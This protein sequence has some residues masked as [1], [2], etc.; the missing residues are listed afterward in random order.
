ME[1]A[2]K[3]CLSDVTGKRNIHF[4]IQSIISPQESH[5]KAD[6]QKIFRFPWRLM[7]MFIFAWDYFSF[8]YLLLESIYS[9]LVVIWRGSR[10]LVFCFVLF[11]Y[12]VLWVF[13]YLSTSPF[14]GLCFPN[15]FSKSMVCV[16]MMLECLLKRSLLFVLFFNFDGFQVINL[17]FYRLHYT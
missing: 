10:E 16:L 3:E 4:H 15:I 1:N 7:W 11:S 5:R 8:A 17:F 13:A 12:K 9:N 2:I 6:F 14:L